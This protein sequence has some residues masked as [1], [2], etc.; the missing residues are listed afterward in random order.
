M[1]LAARHKLP[2]VYYERCYVAAG[3]WSPMGLTTSTS[4]GAPPDTSTASS[5]GEPAELPVEMWT[6]YELVINLK[7]RRGIGPTVPPN[8]L[9]QVP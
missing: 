3:G 5:G 4:T 8:A 6:N 1:T 9:L 2:A 7:T